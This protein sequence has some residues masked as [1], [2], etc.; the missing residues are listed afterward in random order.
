MGCI[1]K[2]MKRVVVT[3]AAVGCLTGVTSTAAAA[4]ITVFSAG[5]VSAVMAKLADDFSAQFGSNVKFTVGTVGQ[6]QD[7]I[8]AGETADVV[9]VTAEALEELVKQGKV[10]AGTPVEVG[11]VGVGV[12]VREGAPLPDISTAAA[13]RQ[14]LLDAKSLVYAD[15]AK[16]ASSG[17][18]FAT[19]LDKLGIADAVKDKSTLLPGGFVVEL[20]AEGKAEI[21]VHQIT[22]I[23]PVHGVTLVGPLPPELQKVTTYSGGVM[24]AAV[25]R[26]GA[27]AFLRF[28]TSPEAAPSF[29]ALGFGIF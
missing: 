20:V 3:A 12:A 10:V 2:N 25:N 17:I 1:G 15:P 29:K 23:V 8:A 22:E 16:G 18:Y 13:F 11:K 14:T 7:R 27:A 24:S 9:F 28:V 19:V 6:L 5:A 4:D 21:G 26:D